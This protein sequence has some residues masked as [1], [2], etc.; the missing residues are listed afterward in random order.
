MILNFLR[1]AFAPRRACLSA[2]TLGLLLAATGVQAAITVQTHYRLGEDD[3]GAAAGQA[4][5]QT[6]DAIGTRH[7]EA[8]FSPVYRNDVSRPAQLQGSS[9]GI[10]FETSNNYARNNDFSIASDNFGVELWVKP[11]SLSAN[12]SYVVIG[13]GVTDGWSIGRQNGNFRARFADG[14]SGVQIGIAAAQLNRWTHLALVRANGLATFYVDGVASGSST[15]TPIAPQSFIQ[16]GGEAVLD[17]VRTFSFA[18]GQFQ[19]TDLLIPFGEIGVEQP[20]GTSLASGAGV[21]FGF[22]GDGDPPAT[23]TFVVSNSGIEPLQ[24]LLLSISGQDAAQFG[25]VA[26]PASSL[27][28]GATT[29]FTVQYSPDARGGARNAVLHIGSDDADENDFQVLLTGTADGAPLAVTLPSGSGATAAEQIF[30]AAV[31]PGG[32]ATAVHFEYGA[33]TSYG[34]DSATVNLPA[35][36]AL[37]RVVLPVAGLVAGSTYHYRVVATSAAGTVVGDDSRFTVRDDALTVQRW[38]RLGETDLDAVTGTPP[39]TSYDNIGGDALVTHDAPSYT[40]AVGL[41]AG[42]SGSLRALDF[43]GG[44]PTADS[45]ALAL[46]DN[47]GV[48]LFVRP[49]GSGGTLIYNGN[50]GANGWGLVQQGNAV[51]AL[52][53]GVEFFGTT[54]LTPGEWTH[55]ALVRDSGAT[56]LYVGGE[57]AA[58]T[59]AAPNPASPIGDR[60]QLAGAVLDEVRVFTFTAGSFDIG[61]L[62]LPRSQIEIEQPAAT[63]LTEG[64]VRDFGSAAAPFLPSDLQF[65]VRNTGSDPLTSVS[66]AFDGANAADFSVLAA[67]AAIV[68]PAAS[69]TFTVRFAPTTVGTRN[70]TLRVTSNAPNG[71]F[72]IPL[73]GFGV[74]APQAIS[75]RA[76]VEGGT[77]QQARVAGTANAGGLS[78]QVW[79]QYGTSMVYDQATTPVVLPAGNLDAQDLSFALTGL[80]PGTTYHY[81]LYVEN[82]IG[83]DVGEDRTFTTR[84][85]ALNVAAH[86]RF[87]EDDPGATVGAGATSFVDSAGGAPLLIF[88]APPY[89]DDV[90]LTAAAAHSSLATSL[91]DT[92]TFRNAQGVNVTSNFGHEFWVRVDDNAP[93]DHFLMANGD[94]VQNGWI[95]WKSTNQFRVG[96][97]GTSALFFG[98]APATPGKWTHLALVNDNGVTTF[99]VDGVPSGSSSETVIGPSAA[100]NITSED[101]DEL[102][103]FTFAPGSFD[104]DDLL[105]PRPHLKVEQPA[106]VNVAD[107]GTRDFGAVDVDSSADLVFSVSNDSDDPAVGVT[108]DLDGAFAAQFSVVTPP[109]ASIPPHGS[110]SFTVRFSPTFAGPH[111][112][113][114]HLRSNDPDAPSYDVALT[115]TGVRVPIALTLPANSGATLNDGVLHAYIDSGGLPTQVQFEYGTTTGYGQLTPIVVLP[116]ARDPQ[117]VRVVL[118]GLAPDTTHHV[119]VLAS[120][121]RGSDVGD[122]VSFRTRN[123]AL[124]VQHYYRAGEID[125]A[126][127]LALPTAETRDAVGEAHLQIAV[128]TSPGYSSDVS[129]SA[130]TDAGSIAALQLNQSRARGPVTQTAIDDFGIEAWIRPGAQ[131]GNELVAYNGHPGFNGWGLLREGGQLKALYGGVAL[132]GSVSLPADR[133]SHVALVRQAGISTLYLDAQAIATFAGSP[134]PPNG[135]FAVLSDPVNGTSN[136]IGNVDEVRVFTFAPGGFLPADLIAK[137][138]DVSLTVSNQVLA[139]GESHDFADEFILGGATNHIFTLGNRGNVPLSGIA[140]SI[141]PGPDAAEFIV[142]TAPP[143]TLAP[144]ASAT[145]NVRF[146]PTEVGNAQATLQLASNDPDEQ[147]FA[148]VLTGRGVDPE[149]EIE[150]PVGDAVIDGGEREFPATVLGSGSTLTFTVRNPGSGHLIGLAIAIEGLQADQFSVVAPPAAPVAPGG[151]TTFEVRFAPTTIGTKAAILRLSSN[152]RDEASYD[153]LLTGIGTLPDIAVEQ[154]A[155]APLSDGGAVSFGAAD[156]L[157]IDRVFVLRNSGSG[158]LGALAFAIDGADAARF[159]LIDAATDPL[160]AGSSRQFTVRFTPAGAGIRNANLHIASN[161]PDEASFDI[162]L[163]ADSLVP[164]IG[165]QQPVGVD[166]A[167]GGSRSFGAHAQGTTADLAFTLRN[168]GAGTLRDLQFAIDGANAGEFS[169]TAPPSAT[170]AAGASA[171]F[172]L[173]FTPSGNGPRSAVLHIA[174]NDADEASFDVAVSGNASVADIAVAVEGFDFTSGNTYQTQTLMLGESRVFEFMLSNAGGETLGGLQATVIDQGPTVFSIEA[175]PPATLAAGASVPLGLR[176]TPTAEGFV[177]AT[178]QIASDD[179]DENPFVLQLLGHTAPGADL[180]VS[181]S[182]QVSYLHPGEDTIYTI[183]VLNAGPSAV[184]QVMVDQYLNGYLFNAQWECQSQPAGLCPAAAGGNAIQHLLT[185]PMPPQALLEY[186]LFAQQNAPLGGSLLNQVAVYSNGPVGDPHPDNNVARDDDRV[187]LD[188]IFVSGFEGTSPGLLRPSIVE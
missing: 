184:G 14:G 163:S 161:D 185:A 173:H 21:D 24:G 19:I 106:T 112:A 66:L 109:A 93:G 32:L 144:G 38:Y 26:A 46:V 169:V 81:R 9:L 114:L 148:V 28:V 98:G 119:R 94:G 79:I 69:T 178:L 156:G 182:N 102:R 120:S 72:D 143:A 146:A 175:Q 23:R 29:S 104:P 48:E 142:T 133:W 130:A 154:P 53:G 49:S 59:A 125:P 164:E 152:D 97:G 91:H 174:S 20:A 139:D 165:V 39:L 18:P 35:G 64:Q 77:S 149:I 89:L 179:P 101:Y 12:S 115:A 180:Q 51:A 42:D 85:D 136:F 123:D 50:G 58:T 160:P 145:F 176:F 78:A 177:D 103:F 170:L 76:N 25:I 162:A 65:T 80:T 75:G 127:V 68:A 186:T 132:W 110:T 187:L 95:F 118:T 30:F 13:Q 31:N 16:L 74:A 62:L 33:D 183:Q 60:F 122:D 172:T 36:D 84:N 71:S 61:D 135:S 67:P 128:G 7:M 55:V 63:P 10:K 131:S 113:A 43:S 70:A 188:R 27:A 88:T 1:T 111:T 8:H 96:L 138:P 4:V 124:T 117:P 5:T 151:S 134:N 137:L 15:A 150:Q 44:L 181:V 11:T 57:I 171:A 41:A 45:A 155:G 141:A 3:P 168:S 6:R 121:E 82:A 129:A 107:G 105:F 140:A 158:D 108:L 17:D 92:S 147:P 83:N 2:V 86:F 22:V 166:I 116:G 34:A 87:G 52:F 126:R 37:Q 100:L 40:T 159:S 54:A 56:T 99:Y 73:T 90:A 47:F 157:P 153:L 167:D